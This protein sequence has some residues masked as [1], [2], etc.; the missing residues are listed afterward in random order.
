MNYYRY[1]S[2]LIFCSCDISF[3]T[4]LV[5][6][7]YNRECLCTAFLLPFRFR[8]LL[9]IGLYKEDYLQIL[10]CIIR[11]AQPLWFVGRFGARETVKLHQ[12]D[13]SS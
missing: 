13:I 10:M 9:V 1:A 11:I 3:G 6:Y 12:L 8:W 7:T 2:I 5:Y 4:T